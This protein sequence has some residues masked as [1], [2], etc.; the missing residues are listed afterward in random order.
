MSLESLKPNPAER[1]GAHGEHAPPA[2]RKI[3]V[4]SSSLHPMHIVVH[5]ERTFSQRQRDNRPPGP[6]GAASRPRSPSAM[7]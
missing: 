2:L 5:D 7:K 1:R 4:L 3:E 6:V